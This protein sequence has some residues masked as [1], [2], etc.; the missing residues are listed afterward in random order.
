[1]SS[2]QQLIDF[3]RRG[4]QLRLL[5]HLQF[6]RGL[7]CSP[8]AI[9]ATLTAVDSFAGQDGWCFAAAATIGQRANFSERTVRQALAIL[10]DLFLVRK[11][12]RVTANGSRQ[13]RYQI[14]WS[15]V[16]ALI[17]DQMETDAGSD[18]WSEVDQRQDQRQNL[19]SQRQITT[20][21][22]AESARPNGGDCRVTVFLRENLPPLLPENRE[23]E[24]LELLTGTVCRSEAVRLS[25]LADLDD[26][27][28][29][30]TEYRHPANRHRI[31][32]PGA[33]VHR[34]EFGEWPDAS[35]RTLEQLQAAD[36]ARARQMATAAALEA[37]RSQRDS[38]AR[39]RVVKLERQFA[40]VLDAMSIEETQRLARDA[41][42]QFNFARFLRGSDY[43]FELLEALSSRES[44]VQP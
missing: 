35:I 15:N 16:A 11:Q 38:E 43:R 21:P 5:G 23:E 39:Q 13:S 20:E 42:D 28:R 36:A 31:R 32:S 33:L 24:I 19:Q 22:T 29:A 34:L 9:K 30:V 27:R 40:P 44:L 2:T 6:E 10:H 37:E 18:G 14:V 26:C 41:L 17:D 4:E 12:Q 1:M 25:Q 8:G 3:S 7:G